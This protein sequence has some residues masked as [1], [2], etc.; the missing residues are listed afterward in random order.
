M[1]Y[2]S[3]CY[4]FLTLQRLSLSLSFSLSHELQIFFMVTTVVPSLSYCYGFLTL[5]LLCFFGGLLCFHDD[6]DGHRHH[7]VIGFISI[8]SISLRV[9]I[10]FMMM[11]V[12]L[13]VFKEGDVMMM[14]SLSSLTC[15]SS[16]SLSPSLHGFFRL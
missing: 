3:S 6:D 9:W 12:I 14:V 15:I 10:F 13:M 7:R 11:I 4:W 16:S 5:H 1:V 2:S 8:Y